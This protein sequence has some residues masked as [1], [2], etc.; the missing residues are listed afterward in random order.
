MPK[1]RSGLQLARTDRG[2]ETAPLAAHSHGHML[3]DSLFQ[4]V[5]VAKV[6][7]GLPTTALVA[8]RGTCIVL[9]ELF[10]SQSTSH[11]WSCA[12]QTYLYNAPSSTSSNCPHSPNQISTSTQTQPTQPA[13]GL[14]SMQSA[15]GCSKCVQSQL[16]C[17]GQA[18][19]RLLAGHGQIQPLQYQAEG[20]MRCHVQKYIAADWSPCSRW[21]AAT[22]HAHSSLDHGDVARDPLDSNV[23]VI[24]TGNADWTIIESPFSQ[25]H[26]GPTNVCHVAG[27]RTMDLRWLP[28]HSSCS[29]TTADNSCSWLVFTSRS[30]VV[31][32]TF[33]CGLICYDVLNNKMAE[34]TGT[35]EQRFQLAV[36]HAAS[37]ND[38]CLGRAAAWCMFAE[39]VITYDL[40]SL[41]PTM[42]FRHSVHTASGHGLHGPAT[43]RA[44]LLSP[45]ASKIAIWWTSTY[46][47]KHCV[48]AV[49]D[50]EHGSELASVHAL[51]RT[52]GDDEDPADFPFE[53]LGS[54]FSVDVF[55]QLHFMLHWAPT[56]NALLCCIENCY[57]ILSLISRSAAPTSVRPRNLHRDMS[58][59]LVEIKDSTPAVGS[60]PGGRFVV[61]MGQAV[62]LPK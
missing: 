31:A 25:D 41:Q 51:D 50:C 4:D 48:L 28:T 27:W 49:Y 35:S 45:D 39:E 16:R 12:A 26:M 6:L 34:L 7:P 22:K 24:D 38:V 33:K 21:I 42:T 9:R 29:T 59:S 17:A 8:L 18:T 47:H 2:Q 19:Q 43:S 10:D 56:S 30:P 46:N 15:S 23:Q 37:P 55:N 32:G 20:A 40:P 3:S 60:M 11:I 52:N 36:S 13:A 44:I 54:S 57:H 58:G 61:V 5:L 1:M 53:W 62:G 14:L